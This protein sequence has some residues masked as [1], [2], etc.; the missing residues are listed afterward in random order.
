MSPVY[1]YMGLRRVEEDPSPAAVHRLAYD[2][3][4]VWWASETEYT[5][6]IPAAISSFEGMDGVFWT[7]HRDVFDA[8][9]ADLDADFDGAIQKH[10]FMPLSVRPRVRPAH[11]WLPYITENE[12]R[13]IAEL[14]LTGGERGFFAGPEPVSNNN[15]RRR[16]YLDSGVV[17]DVTPPAF[18]AVYTAEWASRY[19]THW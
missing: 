12:N 17:L 13:R 3:I 11:L 7:Y 14:L 8:V 1:L 4:P 10:Q 2:P 15:A 9:I 6:E 19:A 16:A 5:D 18:R